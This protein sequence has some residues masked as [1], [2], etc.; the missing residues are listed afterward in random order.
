MNDFAFGAA[1]QQVI[2]ATEHPPIE[3][4]SDR[5]GA[6]IAP[7]RAPVREAVPVAEQAATD[8]PPTA[9]PGVAVDP[10]RPVSLPRRVLGL[11][12]KL[13]RMPGLIWVKRMAAFPIGER[14]AVISLTAALWDAKVTFIALLAWGLFATVYTGAGRFL[15]SV[16][17]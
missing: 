6:G 11:W 4:P 1:R 15:R 12:R 16:S 17:R 2:G 9:E 3:Q 14:F 13:D 5:V 7:R 8:A 10:P